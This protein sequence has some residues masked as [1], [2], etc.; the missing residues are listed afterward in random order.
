MASQAHISCA[1]A[2]LSTIEV[3]HEIV[4][5]DAP[6][7]HWNE[8]MNATRVLAASILESQI[9]RDMELYYPEAK[10]VPAR[11]WGEPANR[12]CRRSTALTK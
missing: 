8:A 9:E 7:P 10:M 11:S 1:S 5:E 4:G 3:E 6:V 12:G 2:P